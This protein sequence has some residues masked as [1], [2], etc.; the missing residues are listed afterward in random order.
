MK[1][2]RNIPFFVPHAG[3]PNCCV[4]CSQTKI[5]GE[6][7]EKALSQEIC[8]LRKLLDSETERFCQNQIGFFGGSFTA[9]EKSRME[10]LL[11]VANEYIDK[12]VA[13]SIRIS[14]RPDKI[15]QQVLGI[16]K[17]YR[18][19]NIELG[20]QS[21]CDKV[22]KAS[23]RG[24]IASDSF[25]AAEM[26]TKN[27]FVFGGQ[28]MIGLPQSTM[29][30]EIQTALD[31]VKM[32]A[33]EARIYPTVVFEGTKLFEMA[34]SGEYTPLNLDDAVER[35]AKCYKIF[36]DAKVKLLRIGLHSSENLANAPLG[37]NHPAIGE[38]VKSRVYTDVI[39]EKCGNIQGKI[40]E[41]GINKKDISTL[42]GH[43]RKGINRI[44][45]ET[46]ASK[47]E[48]YPCDAPQFS[49]LIKIRSV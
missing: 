4:F 25:V 11:S 20:V 3:C 22:L 18:V 41:I 27:G 23:N 45:N 33:K 37:A 19:T 34:K 31:I 8:E 28:M 13:E 21:T 5:T 35:T 7:C 16:L 44:I 49:P 2:H 43:N 1:A 36:L 32:G 40:L 9:I 14:T 30:T 17:K 12:G 10:K 15:D 24:H 26:I 47:V 38:L 42:L 6:S 39:F 48:I 29:E 46:G